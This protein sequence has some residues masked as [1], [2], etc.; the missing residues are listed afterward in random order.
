MSF[1]FAVKIVKTKKFM[2]HASLCIQAICSRMRC[3]KSFAEKTTIA[4]HVYKVHFVKFLRVYG[5]KLVY[6]AVAK[7]ASQSPLSQNGLV[8]IICRKMDW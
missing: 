2:M 6:E 3:L 1:S 8:K 4:M 7:V 5:S